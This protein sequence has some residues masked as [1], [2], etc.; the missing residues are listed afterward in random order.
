MRRFQAQG[1][2]WDA[3]HSNGKTTFL[4]ILSDNTFEWTDD[5]DTGRSSASKHF[6]NTEGIQVHDGK[7]YFMAKE[8]KRMLIL[9][10]E[11]NTYTTEQTG[12]KFYG[13][14]DFGE[15]PDQNLFGATRK[16]LYFTE[17][18]GKRPGVYARFGS[19]GTYF[20]M[21]EADLP[22]ED[23]TIG[24]ALSPDHK[25]FYAGIQDLGYIYEFTRDDG[26]PF[27]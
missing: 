19:D 24:I 20:T 1:S 4:N 9:D 27:E 12:K 3:L 8:L 10:L 26:L 11:T 14:G 2:G 7:V 17:D 18:G 5:E 13:E 22:E 25:K 15:Q 16:Y 23:E 6:P 21:F